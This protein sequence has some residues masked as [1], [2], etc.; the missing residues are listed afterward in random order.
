MMAGRRRGEVAASVPSVGGQLAGASVL[1]L[2]GDVLSGH[3]Q[4]GLLESLQSR[5]ERDKGE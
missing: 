3:V 5:W 1:S 2:A 4:R